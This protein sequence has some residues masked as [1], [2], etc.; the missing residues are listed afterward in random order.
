[1]NETEIKLGKIL[2]EAKEM[3]EQMQSLKQNSVYEKKKLEQK[4]IEVESNKKPSKIEH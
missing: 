1:M 2:D 4:L 3:S